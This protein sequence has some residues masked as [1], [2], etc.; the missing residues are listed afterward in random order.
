LRFGNTPSKRRDWFCTD[1]QVELWLPKILPRRQLRGIRKK[2]RDRED[3]GPRCYYAETEAHGLGAEDLADYA[4]QVIHSWLNRSSDE[5][6][7]Q[8]KLPRTPIHVDLRVGPDC[9]RPLRQTNGLF[10]G[11]CGSATNYRSATN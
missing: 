11:C 7:T 8:E 9:S 6:G 3:Y 5:T 1:D 10:Y 4:L 2:Q